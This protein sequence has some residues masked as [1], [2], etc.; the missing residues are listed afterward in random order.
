MIPQRWLPFTQLVLARIREFYR[1]P[2][3]LF[4]VYGFPLLLA[5]GLGIAFAGREPERPVVDVQEGPRAAE[6]EKIL[7]TEKFDVEVHPKTECEDR[8]VKGKTSLFLVAP[9]SEVEY[10]F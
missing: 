5:V 9:A 3:V 1:E 4:W 7:A 6:I 2:E 8:L 10:H